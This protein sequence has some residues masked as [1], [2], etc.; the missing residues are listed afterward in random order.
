MKIIVGA[1]ILPPPLPPPP[2]SFY[3]TKVTLCFR[4]NAFHQN[5]VS[6]SKGLIWVSVIKNDLLIV[7]VLK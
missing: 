2:E 4:T 6:W 5:I 7:T 1:K 3:S